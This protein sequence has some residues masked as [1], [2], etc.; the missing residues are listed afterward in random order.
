VPQTIINYGEIGIVMQAQGDNT[1]GGD[2]VG[3]D[4]VTAVTNNT[5]VNIAD[6]PTT[7]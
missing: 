1:V 3:R 4:K 5:E 6:K 2:V 7:E